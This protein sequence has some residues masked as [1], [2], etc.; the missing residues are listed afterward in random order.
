V[1]PSDRL[2]SASTRLLEGRTI[3]LGVTGSIAAV[4]AVELAREL[5][6]HGARVV[7]VMTREA[8]RIVHANALEFATGVKPIVELTGAVEHVALM[9]TGAGRA[10]LLLVAPATGNTISKMAHGI[11]DSPVTTFFATGI[12][13]TPVLVA[14]AMHETMHDNPFLVENIARLAKAGVQFVE[15]VMEE[16]KAKLAEPETIVEH[17]LRALGSGLLKGKRVLVVNGATQEPIDDMRVVSNRSTGRTGVA[18]AR[19]AWRLGADVELWHAHGEATLPAH[20]RTRRFSTVDELLAMAPDARAFDAILVPAAL[21][22]YGPERRAVGKI[23]SRGGDMELRLRALP[24][25]LEALRKH[26]PGG[27]LVPFKAESGVGEDEFVSRARASASRVR[28]A[29]VVANRLDH[30][31]AD[32]TRALLVDATSATPV[33]GTKD[34]VARLVL[35]RLAKEL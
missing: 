34:A 7:P 11:D 12:A 22:D 14:P 29:F 21:S 3:V 15:P 35:E 8:Q 33:E 24:K 4:R 28:A 25:A 10:D 18:L 20:V 16:G 1:H 27:A 5:L 2:R 9:G 23:P 17:V 6:R 30:V 13:T 26:C 32:R 31:G 19:E